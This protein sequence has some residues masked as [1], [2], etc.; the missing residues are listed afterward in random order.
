MFLSSR[1]TLVALDIGSYSV[2]LARLEKTGRGYELLN[3]G[4]IPLPPDTL[5]DGEIENPEAITAV[6]RNIVK[7]EKLKNKN[8][9]VGI[10]G[11]SVII[12]KISVP[13][14][15]E[16]ELAEMIREEASQ[17]IPFDIEEVHLDFQ[18]V[19]A[20]GEIPTKKGEVA[21]DDERQMDVLIVAA[22]KETIQVILDVAKDVGLRV[23]VVD[24]AV[25]ALENAFELNY[26]VD[27]ESSV[28]LV[29]IGAS[30]TNVNVLESG[31]TAFT[32]D[33]MVGGNTLSEEIQKKLSIGFA[34]A[35]K[36]KLGIL[37][38]GFTKADVIPHV[39]T[40]LTK[41]CDELKRTFDIFDKTAGSKISK[42]YMSGGACLMEGVET[43]I[44]EHIGIDTEVLNVFRNIRFN[45]K[46]FDDDYLESM[47]ALAAIPIGL[48]MRTVG[49]K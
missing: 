6:L 48:A 24:L 11:Q 45:S 22:R 39:K 29:N 12:K 7:A 30:S 3:F 8:I 34:D 40:G 49:D 9:V 28:A 42:V 21:Q 2:K 32:R 23:R 25:F 31:V 10:S 26:E 36:L 27:M 1:S 33:L 20:D 14:M 15:S 4:M 37:F 41:I 44:Q 38:E 16:D 17:Y 18:I 19:K 43:L 47:S 13:L 46:H 35:E 5:I